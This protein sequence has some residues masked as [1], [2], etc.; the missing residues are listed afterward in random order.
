MK[1]TS[2]S[3]KNFLSWVEMN[4][5]EYDNELMKKLK[6]VFSE[7]EGKPVIIPDTINTNKKFPDYLNELM[8]SSDPENICIFEKCG[9]K[10]AS[11]NELKD[12]YLTHMTWN[13]FKCEFNDCGKKYKSKENL[14]LH[15]KNIHMKL[16]PYRC[17]FCDA[18]FSHRNGKITV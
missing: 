5:N 14:V 17:R 6:N 2:L 16:K 7:N 9:R 8:V 11:P 13:S 1:N 3:M 4:S 10:F 12:H 18:S 15:I